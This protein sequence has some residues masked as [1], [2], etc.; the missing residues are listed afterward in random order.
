MKPVLPL[1]ATSGISFGI[2]LLRMLFVTP[3]MRDGVK[4]STETQL[5]TINYSS[6]SDTRSEKLDRSTSSES[7]KG[8]QEELSLA[9][10]DKKS[11]QRSNRAT[12][13]LLERIS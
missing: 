9:E 4:F 11:F 5:V 6:R 10:V 1:G 8:K 13:L 3:Q 7:K 2:F 12:K